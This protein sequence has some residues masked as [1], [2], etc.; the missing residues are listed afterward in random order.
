MAGAPFSS[1]LHLDILPEDI[2]PDGSVAG[3]QAWQRQ[4]QVG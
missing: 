1:F 3:T 2:V 4:G